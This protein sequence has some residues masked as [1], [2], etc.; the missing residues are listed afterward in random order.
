VIRIRTR[1][2]TVQ[3]AAHGDDHEQLLGPYDE[4][5]PARLEVASPASS[6]VPSRIGA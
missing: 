2:A 3:I 4:P 5:V 1:A 6:N